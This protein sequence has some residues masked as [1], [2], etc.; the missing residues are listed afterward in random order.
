MDQNANVSEEKPPQLNP[1][2]EVG[3]DCLDSVKGNGDVELVTLLVNIAIFSEEILADESNVGENI[4]DIIK[5]IENNEEDGN[6]NSNVLE[7]I[8]MDASLPHPKKKF[9]MFLGP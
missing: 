7:E 9:P 2:E 6:E 5:S 1:S 8:T 4:P 3:N